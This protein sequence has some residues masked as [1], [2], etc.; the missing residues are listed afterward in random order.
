M[1]P[2]FEPKFEDAEKVNLMHCID[3]GWISSQG[4]YIEEFEEKFA[5]WNEVGFGVASSNCTTALHLALKA[6]DIGQ[7]DEVICPDLTFIA[8]ANMIHVAGAKP[9][10]VDVDMVSWCLDPAKVV[11]KITPRTKAII[12]VHVFGHAAPMDELMKIADKYNLAV[13]EDVAEAP[14][15]TYKGKMVGTFGHI[16]C[17]SFFA[18]K[19]MTTGEGGISITS[20]A[21]LAKKMKIYRDHGMS[22]ERR[23]VHEVVGFNYRMT[24]MQAAIG[25]AQLAR[26]DRIL[27]RRLMQESR[28]KKLFENSKKIQWRPICE[29]T[30]HVHWMSTITLSKQELRDPLLKHMASKGVDCRQMVYPIHMAQPYLNAGG[31]AEYPNATNISLRSLHLPSSLEITQEQQKIVAESIIEWVEKND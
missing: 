14:G 2:I 7:G 10:L 22:R 24:N 11:E 6:L 4:K 13:I 21:S 18:N 31:D 3:S 29:W 16:A 19:I 30:K 26:I 28:Y 25:V 12:V 15:A 17:Y 1:I 20:D 9:V 23:Y 8:P 27:E 5:L